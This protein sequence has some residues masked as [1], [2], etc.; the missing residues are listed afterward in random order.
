M[1]RAAFTEQ[2]ILPERG[3]TVTARFLPGHQCLSSLREGIVMKKIL[4]AAVALTAVTATPAFAADTV[5]TYSVSGNVDAIC[6]ANATG[7]IA[8]GNLV[9]A[10]GTLNVSTGSASDTGAYC[11]G[12]G[13]TIQVAHASLTT[14]G[15]AA[16][17]FTNTLTFTPK[18]T[19]GATVFTGDQGA[20]TPLGSFS[21]LT[22]EVTGL[23]AGS[24]KPVAG[25]YSGSITVTLSPGA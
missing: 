8:L 1:I 3:A 18:V 7:T 17:G 22:V 9:D 20:A 25:N 13:T 6:S 16:A 11:N 2:P 14:G 12:A 4:M 5:A 23:S 10:N 21:G 19:A 15:A 24:N